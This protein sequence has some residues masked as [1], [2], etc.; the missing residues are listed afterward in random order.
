MTLFCSKVQRL[1]L[2]NFYDS[3]QK[4][5]KLNGIV[6]IQMKVLGFDLKENK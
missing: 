5:P 1:K 6:F 4:S 3:S 2:K